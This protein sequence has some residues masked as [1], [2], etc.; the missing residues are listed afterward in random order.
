MT[1]TAQPTTENHQSPDRSPSHDIFDVQERL[2]QRPYWDKMGAAFTNR[3]G[4]HT[5]LLDQPGQSDK[6]RLQLRAIDRE[7]R[8]LNDGV[9]PRRAPT[10][11]LFTV[12]EVPDAKSVWTR[13][14][15]AF[16]NKDGSLSLVIDEGDWA[17]SGGTLIAL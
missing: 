1:S 6:R 14:G 5:L 15:V 13:V 10:H 8:P 3:D 16:P 17:T 4:S 2:G 11:E 9:D 7:R 12:A